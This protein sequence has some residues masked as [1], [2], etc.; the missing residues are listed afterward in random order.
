ML[1]YQLIRSARRKTLGLQVKQGQVFVRAPNFVSLEQINHFV[2]I[3]AAW[4]K[5]K[6]DQQSSQPV[7]QTMSFTEG[8]LV[9]VYGKAK[10]LTIIFMPIAQVLDLNDELR[11]VIANRSRASLLDDGKLNEAKLAKKVKQQLESWFKQQAKYYL[12]QWL[13]YFSKHCLLH[14]R[15]FQVKKYKARWGSCNSKKELSFNY[16]LVMAPYWVFDYVIVHELCHLAYLNHSSKFW[17]LVAQHFPQ[18]QAAQ[19]WLKDHQMQL[20]WH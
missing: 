6:V 19:T 15:S 10:P 3:K 20:S 14:A 9:W 16:L 4:L 1:E 7:I 11:V 5:E 12:E 2:N 17:Q 8:S 13:P 18:Y